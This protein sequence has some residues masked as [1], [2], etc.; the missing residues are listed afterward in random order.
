MTGD[1]YV[2][3]ASKF[4]IFSFVF[5]TSKNNSYLS[6]IV[7]RVWIYCMID[8][9]LIFYEK[10][11]IEVSIFITFH[12]TELSEIGLLHIHKTVVSL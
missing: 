12:A 10:V 5:K 3:F 6:I 4:S 7:K 1:Y 8:V 2:S 11:S 9:Y